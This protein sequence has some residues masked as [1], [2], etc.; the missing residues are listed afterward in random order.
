MATAQ[1]EIFDRILQDLHDDKGFE[2]V[3]VEKLFY[4]LNK[5]KDIIGSGASITNG[6]T[7]PTGGAD[8]D[9]YIQTTI[10]NQIWYNNAGVWSIILSFSPITVD[11]LTLTQLT[12]DHAVIEGQVYKYVDAGFLPASIDH[13]LL[14]GSG[15]QTYSNIGKAYVTALGRYFPCQYDLSTNKVIGD[16]LIWSGRISEAGGLAPTIDLT[17]CNNLPENPTFAYFDTGKYEFQTSANYFD[18][19][20]IVVSLFCIG[21]SDYFQATPYVALVTYN[22]AN[23]VSINSGIAGIAYADDLLNNSYIEIRQRF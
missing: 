20:K 22:S 21:E 7:V 4:Y 2:N 23:K 19:N 1:Q 16:Y 12:V 8:G 17:I 13:I 5:I 3:T 9:Y 18:V 14:T 10:A 15:T 11:F 6:S